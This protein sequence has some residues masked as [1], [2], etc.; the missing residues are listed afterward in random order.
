MAETETATA[1]GMVLDGMLA[2]VTR[3]GR[4]FARIAERL[5]DA[6]LALHVRRLERPVGD[7]VETAAALFLHAL[8]SA[9]LHRRAGW[10]GRGG[11][12]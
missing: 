3:A 10:R 11:A 2:E 1:P 8:F 5:P 4:L 9:E 7:E 6:E 12:P